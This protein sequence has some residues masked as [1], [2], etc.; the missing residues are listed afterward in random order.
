MMV[1]LGILTNGGDGPGTN[2]AVAS[3][4][5]SSLEGSVAD[6]VVGIRD[7]WAGIY[8]ENVMLLDALTVREYANSSGT[9]LGTSRLNPFN[10][11]GEDKSGQL[12]VK[13]RD[14]G[15]DVLAVIGGDGS[16]KAA[17]ELYKTR[18]IPLVGIP[19]TIDND[20]LGTDYSLGFSSAVD[21]IQRYVNTARNT[22]KS[23]NIIHIIKT[24]GRNAGHLALHGGIATGVGIILI[25]EFA[26]RAEDV[27]DLLRKRRESGYNY[28]IVLVAEN[29]KIK[30]RLNNESRDIELILAEEIENRTKYKVRN[31]SIGF[32][33]RGA[34]TNSYDNEM[35]VKFGN[36]AAELIKNSQVG[37]MVALRKGLVSAVPLKRVT[38]GIRTVNL[39]EDYDVMRLTAK[40]AGLGS[41]VY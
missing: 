40:S 18:G 41:P 17:Y 13:M 26:F 34:P 35:G 25:P 8:N 33:Q 38:G 37:Y 22:S 5:K 30:D 32:I 9:F 11:K 27:V 14:L 3:L 19:Q 12:V 29:A 20:V 21:E 10:V 39:R 1:T 7:G 31:D 15:I 2:Q 6:S 23:M 4:T 36:A 28:D 16:L 24:M